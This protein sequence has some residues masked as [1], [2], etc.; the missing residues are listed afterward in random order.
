MHDSGWIP[1]WFSLDLIHF[2]FISVK[3]WFRPAVVLILTLNRLDSELVKSLFG[4]LQLGLGLVLI[5]LFRL[6]LI[7]FKLWFN[8]NLFSEEDKKEVKET[9]KCSVYLT[10]GYNMLHGH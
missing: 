5:T 4:E 8:S 10:V 9:C 7:H 2:K 6:D 1:K 3:S